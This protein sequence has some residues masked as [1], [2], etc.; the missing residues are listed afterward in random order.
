MSAASTRQSLRVLPVG[1]RQDDVCLVVLVSHCTA[2]GD[3]AAR[4]YAVEEMRLRGEFPAALL[5]S[6]CM[7]LLERRA[8]R[9]TVSV[10]FQNIFVYAPFST[11]TCCDAT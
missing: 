7:V 11:L 2:T 1:K 4:G 8:E 5:K 3:A 10:A 9:A 6:C